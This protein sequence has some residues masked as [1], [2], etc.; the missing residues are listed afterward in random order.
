[1]QKVIDSVIEAAL[2]GTALMLKLNPSIHKSYLGGP[3][4]T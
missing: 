1:M 4:A 3:V 2:Y